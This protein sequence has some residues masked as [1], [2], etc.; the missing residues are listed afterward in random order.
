MTT[1]PT[2]YIV[3]TDKEGKPASVI[4]REEGG[5]I[6]ETVEFLED[7]SPDWRDGGIC[8]SRGPGGEEGIQ[9]LD[10]ALKDAEA[11]AVHVGFEIRHVPK[12]F[13]VPVNGQSNEYLGGA[14]RE[15]LPISDVFVNDAL[16]AL[17]A[18]LDGRGT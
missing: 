5:E 6:L 8:D 4:A 1:Q 11:N 7:G 13:S 9:Q 14:I 16:D 17:L 15:Y 2:I 18:R 3:M 10:R 12:D